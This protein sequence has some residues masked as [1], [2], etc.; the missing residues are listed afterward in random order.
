[1][2][3][4]SYGT[5]HTEEFCWLPSYCLFY[6]VSISIFI[7]LFISICIY[8]HL[9]LAIHCYSRQKDEG[10][11]SENEIASTILNSSLLVTVLIIVF[12]IFSSINTAPFTRLTN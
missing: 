3:L 12:L 2:F 8:L 9:N 11:S 7:S 1:M 10:D 6:Y 4:P 5:I